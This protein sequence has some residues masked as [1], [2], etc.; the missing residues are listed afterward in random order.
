MVA[1]TPQPLDFVPLSPVPLTCG[2]AQ[3]SAP[4]A[5]V[6]APAEDPAPPS[7]PLESRLSTPDS[8]PLHAQIQSALA[9]NTTVLIE[10]GLYGASSGDLLARLHRVSDDVSGVM[11][12]GHNPGLES[13]AALLVA[14]ARAID[15]RSSTLTAV[16]CRR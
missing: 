1:P 7:P 4:A 5:R 15:L 2:P 9:A 10:R 12:I 6:P 16:P 11:L 8:P 3:V 14:A 13:L